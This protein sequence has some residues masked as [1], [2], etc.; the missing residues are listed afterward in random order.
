MRR[1][2]KGQQDEMVRWHHQFKGRKF[3]STPE[4]SKGQGSLEC[5]SPW[6]QKESC[7][8]DLL[9]NDNSNQGTVRTR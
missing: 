5:F 3:E 4:D 9:N 7:M 6:G 2:E 1:Q 8:T